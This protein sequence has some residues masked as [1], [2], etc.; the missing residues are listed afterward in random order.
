MRFS[1]PIRETVEA[2][3]FLSGAVHGHFVLVFAADLLEAAVTG[4][5]PF[6]AVD[7]LAAGYHLRL[8]NAGTGYY[9]INGLL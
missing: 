3:A 7:F 4:L 1:P 5:K 6:V 8:V 9:V 2:N